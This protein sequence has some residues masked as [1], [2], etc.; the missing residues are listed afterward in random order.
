M[1]T[2]KAFVMVHMPDCDVEKP[3][4]PYIYPSN[5][6]LYLSMYILCEKKKKKQKLNEK[7]NIFTQHTIKNC[8]IV[9]STDPLLIQI[10]KYANEE[11]IT[12]RFT[13]HVLDING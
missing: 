12:L 7:K 1:G 8:G 13:I 10:K 9:K 2:A 11:H 4:T 3:S 6:E 5:V